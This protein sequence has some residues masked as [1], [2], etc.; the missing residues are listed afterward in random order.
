MADQ[1]GLPPNQETALLL[2]ADGASKGRY[3]LDTIRLMKGA[4][5]V[6]QLGPS[7]WKELFDFRPYRF[8]PFDSSVYTVR[9]QM[10]R[11]GY[12]ERHGTG[13]YATYVLTSEGEAQAAKLAPTDE[14]LTEWLRSI[15]RW[16][17]GKSF[18]DLLDE[19]YARYPDFAKNSVMR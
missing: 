8:G 13:R 3:S 19:I 15:G 12:L 17:S 4:F 2:I 1:T 18:S 7:D 16:V 9:D 6:E 11:D 10:V 14:K 5:L